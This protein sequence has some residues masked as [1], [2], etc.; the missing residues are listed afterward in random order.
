MNKQRFKQI[1]SDYHHLSEEDV[2]GL[3]QLIKEFPY[4][5]ILHTLVAK[6]NN[7]LKSNVAQQTLNYAAMYTSDRS[8]L[9]EVIQKKPDSDVTLGKPIPDEKSN[10]ATRSRPDKV[11]KTQEASHHKK[12]FSNEDTPITIDT[13]HLSSPSDDLIEEVWK[14]LAALKKSKTNYLANPLAS[15]LSDHKETSAPKVPKKVVKKAEPK[16]GIKANVKPTTASTKRSA[17]TTA[18]KSKTTRAKKEPKKS[19]RS[20]RVTSAASTTTT[21]KKGTS[22]SVTA[23]RVAKTTSEKAPAKKTSKTKTEPEK[24]T[25]S[26]KKKTTAPTKTHIETQKEIIERFIDEEPRISAK[27][28]KSS[29]TDQKDLSEKSTVYNEDLVS[30]NLAQILLAQGKKDKAVEIYKKLIW[31]FPQK[32]SYF[33]TQIQEI[34][35]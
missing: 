27:T 25:T 20:G 10:V 7:D 28:V 4:S 2:T 30:E 21:K 14:D 13:E 34:K 24:K 35:K 11:T 5:Q 8:V 26:V 19:T 3:H 18:T 17:K 9:K 15:N 6:A 1:V 22:K 16:T 31:K 23:K 29:E 33:A 32:R 12:Q